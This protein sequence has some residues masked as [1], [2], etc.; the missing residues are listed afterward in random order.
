MVDDLEVWVVD[1]A[2]Q[3]RDLVIRAWEWAVGGKV[4]VVSMVAYTKQEKA[5]CIS[6]VEWTIISL[7]NV[8]VVV[9]KAHAWGSTHP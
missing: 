1:L 5:H 8:V 7:C 6:H 2:R 4:V 9:D 3:L